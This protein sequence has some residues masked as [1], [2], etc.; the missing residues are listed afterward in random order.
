MA[1]NEASSNSLLKP[2]FCSSRSLPIFCFQSS[3]ITC[4]TVTS[5]LTPSTIAVVFKL[6]K[7]ICSAT[8]GIPT[9]VGFKAS[10]LGFLRVAVCTV[11][12]LPGYKGIS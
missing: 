4:S 5:A 12:L 11:T 7:I 8:K 3:I 10:R 9:V 2:F 6:S 1:L